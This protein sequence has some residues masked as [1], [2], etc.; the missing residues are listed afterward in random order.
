MDARRRKFSIFLRHIFHKTTYTTMA[1]EQKVSISVIS[2]LDRNFQYDV[3]HLLKR[4]RAYSKN[5]PG[6]GEKITPN[7]L[8]YRLKTFYDFFVKDTPSP[9]R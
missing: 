7:A 5:C 8:L 2:K 6:T 9:P 4:A 1:G 3:Y